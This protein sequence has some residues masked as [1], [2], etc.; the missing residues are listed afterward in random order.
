MAWCCLARAVRSVHCG[1]R[2][3]ALARPAADRERGRHLLQLKPETERPR[4]SQCGERLRVLA[5]PTAD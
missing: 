5:G 1:E 2:L 4:G 3:P